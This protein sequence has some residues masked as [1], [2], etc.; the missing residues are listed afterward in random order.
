M[1]K[2]EFK[3]EPDY[4]EITEDVLYLSLALTID[5]KDPLRSSGGDDFD[6]YELF[7]T[8]FG[9]D[10]ESRFVFTCGCGVPGCAGYFKGISIAKNEESIEWH[11]KDQHISYQFN[12]SEYSYSL[13]MLAQ[14]VMKWY[15]YSNDQKLDLKIFP[16]WN[17]VKKI[18][19]LA[20]RID[21]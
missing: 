16:E 1:N 13:T 7:M 10:E 4:R 8:W 3:L 21:Q 11:D 6:I 15:R 12:K 19:E 2:L 18:I 14:E 17:E 20:Q 9:S 5:G